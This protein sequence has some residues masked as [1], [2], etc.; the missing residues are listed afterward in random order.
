MLQKEFDEKWKS[1]AAVSHDSIIEAIILLENYANVGTKTEKWL[2]V[3][4]KRSIFKN[5]KDFRKYM[6]SFE[7]KELQDLFE[8]IVL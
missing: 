7:T 6:E 5:E 8:R 1:Q 2:V 3:N 4:N